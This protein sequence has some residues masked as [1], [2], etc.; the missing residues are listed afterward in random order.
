MKES[1]KID[2]RWTLFLDRDGVINHKIND[3]YVKKWPEFSFIRGAVQALAVLSTLFSRI[4]VVTNQR[5][6]GKGLMTENDL[7]LIHD[8]MM[9]SISMHGGRI[10]KIYYCSEILETSFYRK[11]N[12]GLALMAKTDFP[13][14]DFEKSIMVGD[15]KGDMEFGKKLKMI[16]VYI[17][18]ASNL[19]I[20]LVDLSCSSLFEASFKLRQ[21]Q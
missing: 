12:I 2:S 14:I 6:I 10:D 7:N 15:S 16:T 21:M 19:S 11:P 9:N 5:G 20:E 13:E 8:K 18:S 4:I 17:G 1:I 3:G